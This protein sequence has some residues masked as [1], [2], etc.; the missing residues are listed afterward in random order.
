MTFSNIGL[1][2]AALW[3]VGKTRGIWLLLGSLLIA[4]G[5]IVPVGAIGMPSGVP[6][7]T[8]AGLL[9]WVAFAAFV[10]FGAHA[11]HATS[12]SAMRFVRT[13]RKLLPSVSYAAGTELELL[14]G[15]TR[16]WVVAIG[17]AVP[18]AAAGG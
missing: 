11:R 17:Q 12:G 18:M 4:L 2:Y 6:P 8:V 7:M 3:I 16:P 13:V 1:M 14:L 10:L 5:V 15:T 9:V